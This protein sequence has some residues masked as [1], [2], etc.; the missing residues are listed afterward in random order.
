MGDVVGGNE[1]EEG[2]GVG[3]A[4]GF[5]GARVLGAGLGG[6][7]GAGLG[8]ALGASLGTG[9]G[10]LEGCKLGAAEGTGL[11]SELGSGLGSGL[12][13]CACAVANKITAS[14]RS[15]SR[16]AGAPPVPVCLSIAT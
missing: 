7:L 6:V 9:L 4:V 11:G 1:G 12:G 3:C 14:N 10:A 8:S 15:S 5:V 13:A 2:A 16:L